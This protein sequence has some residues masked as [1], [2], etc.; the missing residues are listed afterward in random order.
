[1]FL[2]IALTILFSLNFGFDLFLQDWSMALLS[3]PLA[4][5]QYIDLYLTYSKKKK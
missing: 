3:G 5:M 4:I 2:D 1:M